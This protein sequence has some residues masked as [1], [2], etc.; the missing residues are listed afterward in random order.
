MV[1]YKTMIRKFILISFQEKI[2]IFRI[3]LLIL[4][5]S[6]IVRY[7]PLS[8]YYDRYFSI[9]QK[10][11]IDLSLYKDD[12]LFIRRI[13]SVLPIKVSCLIESMTAQDYLRRH[14][15]QIPISL[16]VKVSNQLF[17]HAW[18]WGSQDNE[19]KILN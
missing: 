3:L 17:A 16:G 4:K 9:P 11:L 15:I 5:S 8:H 18:Y 2:Q 19:F 12:I 1:R 6:F 7:L 13:L 10:T 14:G